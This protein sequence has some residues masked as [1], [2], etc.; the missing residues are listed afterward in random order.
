MS[1]RS[2]SSKS[3]SGCS[4]MIPQTDQTVGREKRKA[5]EEAGSSRGGSPGDQASP[6]VKRQKC[7]SSWAIQVT[8]ESG[9]RNSARFSYL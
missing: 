6:S 8:V 5:V 3:T 4:S 7:K 2:D 1:Q 9:V